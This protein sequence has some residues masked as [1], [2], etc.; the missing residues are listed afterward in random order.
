MLFSESPVSDEA[1]RNP[2]QS[3]VL[4][5]SA[6]GQLVFRKADHEILQPCLSPEGKYL[7]YGCTSPGGDVKI[8]NLKTKNEHL[9]PYG[10][11]EMG[12]N[13]I[14]DDGVLYRKACKPIGLNPDG[15]I[16]YSNWETTVIDKAE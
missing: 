3:E 10:N 15:S 8:I 9:T 13:G 7:A 16:K 5:F 6:A 14:T 12:F 4:V 2:P 11:D 1:L